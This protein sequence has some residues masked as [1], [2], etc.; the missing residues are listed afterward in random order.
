MF[1]DLR[2]KDICISREISL[3]IK[4][5]GEVDSCKLASE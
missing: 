1:A 5:F 3:Q 4:R 2:D